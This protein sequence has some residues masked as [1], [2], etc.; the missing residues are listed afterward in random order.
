[1]TAHRID[2]AAVL[3]FAGADAHAVEGTVAH[4][5][6]GLGDAV[7]AFLSAYAEHAAALQAWGETHPSDGDQAHEAA[8]LRIQRAELA[9]DAAFARFAP[10]APSAQP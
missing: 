6:G 4:A 8:E 2:V 3:E 7:V 5:L 1:M 10:I 9:L